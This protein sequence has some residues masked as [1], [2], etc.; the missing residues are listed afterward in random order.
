MG[1]KISAEE[2]FLHSKQVMTSM[3]EWELNGVTAKKMVL[4]A[5]DGELYDELR[6]FVRKHFTLITSIDMAC[7][8]AAAAVS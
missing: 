3:G 5:S 2:I 6:Y 7:A 1:E 4:L 8:A